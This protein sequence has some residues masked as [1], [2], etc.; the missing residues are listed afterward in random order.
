MKK[1]PNRG[2]DRLRITQEISSGLKP[3]FLRTRAESRSV[4]TA[5]AKLKLLCIRATTAAFS[6]GVRLKKVFMKSRSSS[7]MGSVHPMEKRFCREIPD[8]QIH[9]VLISFFADWLQPP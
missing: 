4:T 7:V 2:I 5:N 3:S 9:L 8:G 1:C 6:V